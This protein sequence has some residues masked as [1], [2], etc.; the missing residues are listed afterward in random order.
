MA[1]TTRSPRNWLHAGCGK[2]PAAVVNNCIAIADCVGG[3]E[4]RASALKQSLYRGW[5]IYVL[6]YF[7]PNGRYSLARM[8]RSTHSFP[9]SN[10]GLCPSG[11]RN[12]SDVEVPGLGI[13]EVRRL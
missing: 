13:Q 4:S 7:R 2:N 5:R 12:A 10:T 9:L 3:R 8:R 6:R 1:E 11:I